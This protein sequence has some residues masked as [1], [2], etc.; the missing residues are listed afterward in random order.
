MVCFLPRNFYGELM[1]RLPHGPLAKSV[2]DA[3]NSYSAAGGTSWASKRCSLHWRRSSGS[4]R[5]KRRNNDDDNLQACAM[6][7]ISRPGPGPTASSIPHWARRAGWRFA[8]TAARQSA[9]SRHLGSAARLKR[10]KPTTK[11][12]AQLIRWGSHLL[13]V[14]PIFRVNSCILQRIL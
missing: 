12:P 14:T 6:T 7:L 11:G 3:G 4:V 8:P 2:A 13:K 9:E 1:C 10:Q 5:W